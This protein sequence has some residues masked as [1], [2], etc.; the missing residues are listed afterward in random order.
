MEIIKEYL[1]NAS[2]IDT[3][4]DKSDSAYKEMIYEKLYLGSP[5]NSENIQN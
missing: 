5:D 2:D 4:T 1:S 3:L